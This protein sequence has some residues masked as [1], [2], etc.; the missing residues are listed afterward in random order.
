[1]KSVTDLCEACGRETCEVDHI[2]GSRALELRCILRVGVGIR[3]G[4]SGHALDLS[5]R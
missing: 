4:S 1:M 3:G 2:E 5:R